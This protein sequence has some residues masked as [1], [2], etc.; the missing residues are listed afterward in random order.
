MQWRL[1]AVTRKESARSE[2]PVIESLTCY[3][4]F[5]VKPGYPYPF[6]RRVLPVLFLVDSAEFMCGKGIIVFIYLCIHI[7]IGR[8]QFPVGMKRELLRLRTVCWQ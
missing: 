5:L 4:E 6:A 8:S 7:S 2:T 3:P 1:Q